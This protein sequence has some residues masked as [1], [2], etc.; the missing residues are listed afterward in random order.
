MEQDI[1]T[2]YQRAVN[3]VSNGARFRVNFSERSLKINDRFIIKNGGYEGELGIEAESED[4]VLET[5]ENLYR[6]Y[7]HSTPSERSES[8]SKQYFKALPE[9]KLSD[10]AMFFGKPRELAQLELELYIL[11]QLILGFTWNPETM[12]TWFY[13]GKQDKD[14]VIIRQW[15]EANTNNAI[16]SDNSNTNK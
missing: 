3:A 5:I 15:L 16:N 2:I 4:K 9:K 13:Q 7:K 12:G 6:V 14:L 1:T 8:K 10:D 11:C